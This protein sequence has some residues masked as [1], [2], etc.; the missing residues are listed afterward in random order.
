MRHSIV[1]SALQLIVCILLLS[2]VTVLM[3]QDIAHNILNIKTGA[4]GGS[5]GSFVVSG[6]Q[7]TDSICQ[8]TSVTISGTVTGTVNDDNGYDLIT[9]NLWDDGELKDSEVVRVQIGTTQNVSIT[10]SFNSLYGTVVPGVGVDV[11]ELGFSLDPFYPS[12][13]SGQCSGTNALS[14]SKIGTGTGMVKSSPVGIDCGSDCAENYSSNLNVTLTA[15]ADNNSAFAGWGGD[16]S[17]T[18][19][20]CTVLMNSAKGVTAEFVIKPCT[21][22]CQ[23]QAIPLSSTDTATAKPVTGTLRQQL[24]AL[25]AGPP[26][27][28]GTWVPVYRHTDGEQVQLH[29]DPSLSSFHCGDSGVVPL[30]RPYISANTFID[31]ADEVTYDNCS[32]AFYRFAFTIPDGFTPKCIAGKAN[33]DDQGVVFLNGHR[34]SG[35]MHNPGCNPV[36]ANGASDSCYTQQDWNQVSPK[37]SSGLAILNWPAMDQFSACNISKTEICLAI[38]TSGSIKNEDFSNIK[39]SMADAVRS[40]SVV[41]QDGS[42]TISVVQFEDFVSTIVSPT[43]ITSTAVANDVAN[44][45]ENITSYGGKTAI[46]DAI[47]RCANQFSFT[48]GSRYVINVFTDGVNNQPTKP[49]DARIQAVANGVNVINAL[50][51]KGT[52]STAPSGFDW[53]E[54]NSFIWPQTTQSETYSVFP[55]DGFAIYLSDYTTFPQTFSNMLRTQAFNANYFK[56]GENELVFGIAGDASYYDPTGLEFTAT[57]TG[58]GTTSST[59]ALTVAKSGTGTVTSNPVGID[60]GSACSASFN[61]GANVTLTASPAS[62]TFS[63]GCT[64]TGTCTVTM[65]AAKTVTVTFGSGTSYTLS[66]SKAGSGTVTSYP[67]GISCGTGAG[68]SASFASGTAV[69]LTATPASGYTFS[70]WSG[71]CSGSGSC[72]VTMNAAKAITAI[73]A[74]SGGGNYDDVVLT[75]ATSPSILGA[76]P[77]DDTYILTPYLLMG[78]ENITI[79]DAQGISRLQLVGGLSIASSEVAA[80]ALRLTLNNGAV[81]T[82]LGANAFQYD[83]GGN[84]TAGINHTSVS[85]AAFAQ[86]TLGVMIPTTGI[87]IGGPVTIP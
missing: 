42:V 65:D 85:F 32:S 53:N 69:T 40:F 55:S 2:P 22:T 81:V 7:I 47:L 70:Y 60:C 44:K 11:P 10:L 62:G 26:P 37:D 17:G 24:D 57:V 59:Y 38:D 79:S 86:N 14:V 27:F 34:I 67:A 66:V 76:G 5:S 80:T 20:A 56:A 61:S 35:A 13:V 8:S 58:S 16:C 78:T 31:G 28:D 9:F 54:I 52:D 51:V 1:R 19:Y 15:T 68:C 21:D 74:S 25:N 49:S 77:G 82:V 48:S 39:K 29:Q 6:T 41:S 36:A 43:V 50:V 45:I 72:Q 71:D 30:D 3:A 73:F 4:S 18:S 84:A 87:T 33:V 23:T 46:G 75:Q 64:G 12:D 83:V 63:G